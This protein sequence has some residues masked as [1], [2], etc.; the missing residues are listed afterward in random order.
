M[1]VPF[2]LLIFGAM[3]VPSS[4]A[5]SQPHDDRTLAFRCSDE[6]IIGTVQNEGWQHVEIADD[7]LGHGWADATLRIERVVKGMRLPSTIHVR[8]FGHTYMREDRD[9]MLVLRR[10]TLGKYIIV[11]GQTMSAHPLLA[12]DCE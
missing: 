12:V 9:F 1:Q 6:V 2:A 7:I 5:F 3:T 10:D 4:S 8:Y 11:T